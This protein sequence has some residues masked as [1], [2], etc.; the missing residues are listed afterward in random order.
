MEKLFFN[1]YIEMYSYFPG[2]IYENPENEKIVYDPEKASALLAEAGW[3]ERNNEGILVKDGQPFTITALYYEKILERHLTIFQEDLKKAG[4][5]LKLQLMDWSAMLKLIDERNF[6]L[7]YLGWTGMLFPNPEADYHS[8]Y[9]DIEQ[10]NNVTGIKDPR[11]DEILEAYPKM[12][13]VNKRI[14][15]LRELDGLIYKQYPYILNWY[16]PFSRVLYWNRFGMPESYVT[17]FGGAGSD[18][19]SSWWYDKEKDRVL[20]EA[21]KKKT[22]LPVGETEVRYWLK[23]EEE[24]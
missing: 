2:S 6:D 8:R 12:F 10:T 15:A 17:K 24:K 21:M 9:A 1:E 11:I 18:I 5:E 20:E 14:E 3:G 13:D 4:I 22:A 7:T 23:Q 19:L 16:G